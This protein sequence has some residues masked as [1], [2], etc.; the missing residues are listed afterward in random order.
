MSLKCH[1]SRPNPSCC[2]PT[3]EQQAALDRHATPSKALAHYLNM[4][5]RIAL[6]A[7]AVMTSVTLFVPFFLLGVG[8]GLY[9]THFAETAPCYKSEIAG[10]G[11]G[12]MENMAN[13]HFPIE[14][15]LLA[16]LGIT[17]CHL[18]HHPT[19]F[20]PYTAIAL[21]M[22]TGQLLDA[23]VT[24]ACHWFRPATVA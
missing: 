14:I 21:G 15:S 6:G 18:D 17:V 16:N 20:V 11:Q 24:K 5:T 4:I 10:C 3:L 23:P 22:W 19:V 13:M 8:I 2:H 9:H 1:L 12:F 7:I